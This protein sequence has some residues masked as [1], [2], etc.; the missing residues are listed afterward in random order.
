MKQKQPS[1]WVWNKKGSLIYG[2]IVY[3]IENLGF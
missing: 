2:T 3:I 1:A